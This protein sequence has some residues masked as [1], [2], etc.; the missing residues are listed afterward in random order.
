MAKRATQAAAVAHVGNEAD[1]GYIQF[2]LRFQA[3]FLT[4]INSGKEPLLTTDADPT[5]MWEAYL[6]A[7]PTRERQYHN[8]SA[9]R[10]F[11]YRFGGLVTVSDAGRTAPAIWNEDDA[12]NELAASIASLEKLVRRAN[13]NGVFLSAIPTLGDPVTGAWR[14]LAIALP[15]AMVYRGAVLTDRQAMAEKREDRK[16]VAVALGEFSREHLEAA[17]RILQSDALY[18]SEKVLGPAEWLLARHVE[19]DAAKGKDAHEN[20]LWRAVA[21]APAG[22]CHPRA[23]M[24]G[25][26]LEDIAAGKGFDECARAFKAKM[27]PLSYQRPQAPP[28]SGAIAAAEKIVA[29]LGVAGSLARRF[30]RVD[31]VVALWRPPAILKGEAK[32]GGV[33]AHLAPKGTGGSIPMDLPAQTMTW[34]KFRDTVLPAAERVEFYARPQPDSY[35]ALVTAVNPDAPPILQWDL[36]EARNPV[37]WYFWN[38]GSAPGQFG[39]T[40][41]AWHVVEAVALK[42]PAWGGGNF[43]HQGDGV[44]FV[45]AGAK[46]SHMAGA[47]IFPEIL[48]SE[49]HG[50]RSVIE[51]Y[52]RAA[53]IEGMESPHACGIMLDKGSSRE[54][55][56]ASFR[57]TSRGQRADYKLD[58]WD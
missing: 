36:P 6:D 51:A 58:R 52:S 21:T 28:S 48:K 40:P 42:P 33:F 26:L 2:L 7:I 37:S 9:C 38:G 13:V 39:L 46:E 45:L 5:A 50:I 17:V 8:C 35:V 16:N 15:P 53:K 56:N 10:H 31:E 22:F 24:V 23:S 27:H 44:L 3:R 41:G 57:V 30:C 14:H 19:R 12:D 55:W 32:A 54:S 1:A 20:L 25:T 43:S 49:F 4:A 47:A 34:A 29:Q 18:R 11:I